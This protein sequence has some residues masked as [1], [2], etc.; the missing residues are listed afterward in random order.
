MRT[1]LLLASALVPLIV[2]QPSFGVPAR[3]TALTLRQP[4]WIRTWLLSGPS[5]SSDQSVVNAPAK[6]GVFEVN[7]S[8]V[9]DFNDRFKLRGP[10]SPTVVASGS[11][12]VASDTE[13]WLLMKTEGWLT[14]TVDGQ[15]KSRR[16][17]P[18][19]RARGWD[20][21]HLHLKPGTHSISLECKRLND[22]WSLA[23]RFINDAG[24]VPAGT[25]WRLPRAPAPS[26]SG[27]D[28]FDVSFE[29]AVSDPAGLRAHIA[30]PLGT[31]VTAGSSLAF[32]LVKADGTAL[33]EFKVG[34]WPSAESSESSL[35]VQLGL[36]SEWAK[37]LENFGNS[38]LI[39]VTAGEYRV[40]RKLTLLPEVMQAWQSAVDTMHSLERNP[41]APL[42]V[43]RATLE[44][45]LQQLSMSA[46]AEKPGIELRQAAANVQTICDAMEHGSMP[47][48]IP[49]IHELGFHASADT[50]LQTF[51]LYVPKPPENRSPMP[52]VV[53]LHG[54]NGTGRRVLDAFLDAAPGKPLPTVNGFVLG[55]AAHGNTFYRGPGERDVLEILD[56][57]LETLPVD[58]NR[59]TITGVSMGGTGTAEIALH[60]PDRFA[61]HAPLCGYHSFYV[62][63]DTSGQ[64]IRA[65]ERK[66]MHRY[67][68]ASSAESGR[69][70]PMYLAHGLKDTPLENSKVLTSR[71]K[72]LGYQIV[73]DWPNLGHA[74]WK[75]TWAHAGLFP[76]L[77][78][79]ARVTDPA[80]V[81][82]ST[83]ALRHGHN[84]WL[85]LTA[86]DAQAELSQLDADASEK[87]EVRIKTK[88]VLAFELDST[89]HIDRSQP[90]HV[91]IDGT[92]LEAPP[93]SKLQFRRAEGTW[94]QGAPPEGRR[95][96]LGAEGPW[97]D[98]WSNPLVF[99]YGSQNPATIGVNLEVARAFAAPSGGNDVSYPTLSDAEYAN[100]RPSGAT[101]I[102][103]GNASDN[104]WLK[105]WAPR[106]PVS[107]S[108]Q[109]IKI[110]TSEF[111]SES[112]GAIYVYPH[113]DNPADIIGV[114]TSP[115]PEGLWQSLS[116]PILLPDFMVFDARATS[117]SGEPI[118]GKY[119]HVLAAGFFESDWALPAQLNDPIDQSPR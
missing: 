56:W 68:S 118:L 65:W 19:L 37:A 82:V 22:R 94:K 31:P 45:A 21:V 12:E 29:L 76:W 15:V 67:S 27:L 77:S 48:Q 112:V 35:S 39:E 47:W 99:V 58:P 90:V 8:G 92:K 5:E 119:A 79:Q 24:R 7:S 2:A 50:S 108:A 110:G 52:L 41:S 87:G 81:T 102:F 61:A 32:R 115:T 104:E 54:Y 107:T 72:S 103:I 111:K 14:V 59:V 28:A 49:G 1:P 75:K 106:L 18:I 113:P 60:F 70:L 93:Q 13:G 117:A 100:A 64:P 109:T 96:H 51:A 84:Y 46:S 17:A 88:G 36:Q 34:T 55:P 114:I 101:A 78:S 83:T 23:A 33:K 3:G 86:L 62:R 89:Q 63:R 42:E 30:A 6:T 57:A 20:A 40:R 44:L 16:H 43:P 66:L 74:V 25:L 9:L 53:V 73:E 10:G 98:L 11:L 91:D 97:L 26:T 105:R 69:H 4:G 71:Y 80:R 95:K 85:T 38:L 116:L